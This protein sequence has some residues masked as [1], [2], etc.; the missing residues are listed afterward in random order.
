MNSSSLCDEKSYVILASQGE[1]KNLIT[2]CCKPESDELPQYILRVDSE[3]R[4]FLTVQNG[5]SRLGVH[6]TIQAQTSFRTSLSEPS[7][8]SLLNVHQIQLAERL[9]VQRFYF[10]S[11]PLRFAQELQRRFD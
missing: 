2:A 6:P 9:D 11:C 8:I 4:S 1:T 7:G 10:I 3:S 5:G